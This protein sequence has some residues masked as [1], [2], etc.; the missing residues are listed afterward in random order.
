MI[1]TKRLDKT[2]HSVYI[3]HITQAR[4][5]NP[6]SLWN[7]CEALST[8]TDNMSEI[9]F[10]ILVN[11]DHVLVYRST[12]S[13]I[14]SLKEMLFVLF[15]YSLCLKGV[16]KDHNISVFLSAEGQAA[17]GTGAVYIVHVFHTLRLFPHF[18]RWCQWPESEFHLRSVVFLYT[19]SP[20]LK[21]NIQHLNWIF[22]P[23]CRYWWGVGGVGGRASGA[24]TLTGIEYAYILLLVIIRRAQRLCYRFVM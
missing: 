22:I 16:W 6:Y 4:Y 7:T 18:P 3:P 2:L 1:E 13:H 20:F 8:C 21:W 9:V 19:V 11:Q 14:L 17:L 12:F 10:G 24:D 5:L 23:L 15:W